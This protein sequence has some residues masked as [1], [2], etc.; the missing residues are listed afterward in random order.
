MKNKERKMK[1]RRTVFM[2]FLKELISF[3]FLLALGAL[4]WTVFGQLGTL[5]ILS[6]GC[7]NAYNSVN[8]AIGSAVVWVAN[9]FGAG[10]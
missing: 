7:L 1:T 9:L 10:L 8:N 5:G 6:E 2:H 4:L 3:L